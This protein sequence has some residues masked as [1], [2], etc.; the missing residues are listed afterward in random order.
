MDR[1]GACRVW[2]ADSGDYC[3]SLLL[4]QEKK[5]WPQKQETQNDL[6]Q[7]VS[8]FQLLVKPMRVLVQGNIWKIINLNCRERSRDM[9]DHHSYT[10]LNQLWNQKPEK[11]SGLNGI[12]TCDL[13]DTSVVLY[14][15]SYQANWELATLW[16]RNIPVDGEECKQIYER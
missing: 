9:I 2:S 7:R 14:L 16:A 12:Q 1:C 11:N 13:C 15:L 6:L 4:L 8:F 10:H 3:N 5:R